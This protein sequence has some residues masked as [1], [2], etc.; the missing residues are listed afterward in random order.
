[1]KQ[2]LSVTVDQCFGSNWSGSAP[3]CW[4]YDFIIDTRTPAEFQLDRLPGAVNWPVL[5]NHQRAT[6]GTMYQHEGAF[7]AKRAGAILVARNIASLIEQHA[8]TID[9]HARL[10]I[11]CWRGGNR[12]GALSTVL[13]RIGFRCDVLE[14]GYKAFRR[15]VMEDTA[16]RAKQLHIQII[17]GRTGSGKTD[18]L[19]Q[20][21][22]QAEQVIDLEGLAKHRGSLL[23]EEPD[24]VQPSQRLFESQL[25][26]S[27]AQCR[28][29]R[30]VW[31]ESE[32]R[33]IGMIQIPESLID[34]MRASTRYQLE[35]N[36]SVRTKYLLNHY[37]HWIDQPERLE[38]Q[39]KRLKVFMTAE[40]FDQL[41]Q[42]LA[43][44]RLTDLVST[45]LEKYYDPLY[46]RSMGKNYR[47]CRQVIALDSLDADKIRDV[48]SS[49]AR[50]SPRID[51]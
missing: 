5:D 3:S 40:T 33:K 30:P 26:F 17:A 8:S 24:L 21:E 37:Q 51:A 38:K 32:S 36:L 35:V 20:L 18:L 22:A 34:R 28:P 44:G 6:I 42:C 4:S 47:G 15:W 14:G 46:D 45:L 1:M 31:L 13:A 41:T 48:A 10:L 19:H 9:K 25:W 16:K 49:L 29:E 43:E 2:A 27:L 50:E 11:Y 12:S 23:G 7:K 39:L